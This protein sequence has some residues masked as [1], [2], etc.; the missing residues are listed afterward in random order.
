MPAW[1]E[2]VAAYN[3]L[4]EPWR[5]ER[6]VKIPTK[7]V[8]HGPVTIFVKTHRSIHES[9]RKQPELKVADLPHSP[10]LT[11]LVRGQTDHA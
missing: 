10:E 5:E 3:H 4:S 7:Y 11:V 8:Y 9:R 1:R 2:S 6:R